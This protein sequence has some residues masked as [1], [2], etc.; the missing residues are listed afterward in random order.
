MAVQTSGTIGNSLIRI[1]ALVGLLAVEE[2]GIK[3]NDTR[4]TSGTTDRSWSRGERSQQDQE[5][6]GRD[7]DRAP[8]NEHK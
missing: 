2:A 3:F 7:L 1:N 4:N 5:Y 8:Q 6:Y